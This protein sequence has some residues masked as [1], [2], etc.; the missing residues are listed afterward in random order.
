MNSNYSLPV[1]LG[2]PDEYTIA[3]FAK[4]IKEFVGW[5][6]IFFMLQKLPQFCTHH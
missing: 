3:E 4:V 1:N 6:H 2:N 5:S